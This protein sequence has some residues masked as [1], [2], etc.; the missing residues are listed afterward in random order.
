MRQIITVPRRLRFKPPPFL[1]RNCSSLRSPLPRQLDPHSRRRRQ[2]LQPSHAVVQPP[3]D[4][5]PHTA[6]APTARKNTTHTGAGAETDRHGTTSSSGCLRP[7]HPSVLDFPPS[8]RL[9]ASRTGSCTWPD[10]SFMSSM[11]AAVQQQREKAASQ[12]WRAVVGWI[13]FLVQVLL[14]ILRGTPSCAQ[15]FPSSASGT[16]SSPGPRPRTR[17]RRWSSCRSAPRSQLTRHLPRH[18]RLSPWAASR[19]EASIFFIRFG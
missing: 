16:R 13:G 11:A 6:A 3:P 10:S 8:S 12:V 19:Y 15:L 5:P 18:L 9:P 17:R 2:R 14:Q 1:D 4:S 7:R